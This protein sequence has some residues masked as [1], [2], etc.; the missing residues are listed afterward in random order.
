MILNFDM[1]TSFLKDR[2]FSQLDGYLSF[3]TYDIVFD[4]PI[5]ISFLSCFCFCFPSIEVHEI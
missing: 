1:L 2:V 5:N 3:T 4:T